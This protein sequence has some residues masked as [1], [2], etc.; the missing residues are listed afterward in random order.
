MKPIGALKPTRIKL[1][2]EHPT[3]LNDGETHLLAALDALKECCDHPDGLTLKSVMI[4][5]ELGAFR[6]IEIATKMAERGILK[7]S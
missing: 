1:I 6:A 7:V 5:S 2:V 3:G 4:W